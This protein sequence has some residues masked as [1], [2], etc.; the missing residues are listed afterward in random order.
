MSGFWAGFGEGF[1]STFRQKM[2]Q[3]WKSE[4]SEK[5]RDWEE[6]MFLKRLE[7]ERR[8]TALNA[9]IEKGVGGGFSGGAGGGGADGFD[10][11][12]AVVN[13]ATRFPEHKDTI[14][15]IAG[16]PTA[17]KNLTDTLY[18]YEEENNVRLDSPQF[19]TLIGGVTSRD[20][21]KVTAD[22]VRTQLD[23]MGLSEYADDYTVESI[24]RESSERNGRVFI[25]YD[26]T[27][28]PEARLTA[29]DMRSFSKDLAKSVVLPRVE[30]D[31]SEAHN[32]LTKL[33][34]GSP[35]HSLQID[36]INQ[37]K[38][39]RDQAEEGRATNEV[40]LEYAAPEIERYGSINNDIYRWFGVDP[41]QAQMT[42]ADVR[43]TSEEPMGEPAMVFETVEEAQ[44][45]FNQGL[46]KIGDIIQVGTQIDVVQ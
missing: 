14:L 32:T 24:A 18:T 8:N 20:A 25:D 36:T 38:S 19:G 26:Y 39:I 5:D 33:E 7:A 27:A 31:L 35:E 17:L 15:K 45:A 21:K 2:D 44:E 42:E 4:E 12:T 6:E 34:P 3:K 13:L 9:L 10:T 22:D 11:E 23:A 30:N 41:E 16:D 1:S 29:D 43:S 37:L 46:I 40:L 28:F